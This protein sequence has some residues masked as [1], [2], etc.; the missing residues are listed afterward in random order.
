MRLVYTSQPL[1]VAGKTTQQK[2]HG[3]Q[4]EC[5]R[6]VNGYAPHGALQHFGRKCSTG[7]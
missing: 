2:M 6:G 3:A 7:R 4:H 5:A 1:L